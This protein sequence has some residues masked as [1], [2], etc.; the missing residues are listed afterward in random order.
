MYHFSLVVSHTLQKFIIC[1]SVR[2]HYQIEVICDSDYFY[3]SVFYDGFKHDDGCSTM[4]K[5]VAKKINLFT[6]LRRLT[7]KYF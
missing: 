1:I 7:E 2:S 5:H 4:P 3:T 6:K